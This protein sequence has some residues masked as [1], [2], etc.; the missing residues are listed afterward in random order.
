MSYDNNMIPIPGFEDYLINQNGDIYS[1]KTNK[2]L[3]PWLDS[4]G[5]LQIQLFKNGS[6]YCFKVHR[7]VAKVFI[8]NPLHLPEINHK[9]E[10][11]QNPKLTNLEWCTTKYN[12][13]Y[14]TR[15]ER[16][17]KKNRMNPHKCRK[18]IVQLDPD[19]HV[20]REYSAIEKVKDFGFCQ[21]NVIA[22]LKHRRKT[23]GGYIFMYK[24]EYEY[25]LPR[26]YA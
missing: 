10:N 4:K 3:K 1:T 25:E 8:P 7:L 18:I 17:S 23:T 26:Y 13:N 22:V 11:K 24:E 5:Y 16:I 15:G 14:G 20:I 2:F 9:D 6:K 19:F 12:S 21:P